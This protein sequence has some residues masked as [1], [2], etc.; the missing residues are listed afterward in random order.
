MIYRCSPTVP[1]VAAAVAA[2]LL[3]GADPVRA[4]IYTI[5]DA[6]AGSVYDGLLDGFPFPPPG[7]AP[8]G[9][10][11]QTT[12]TLAVALLTGVTEERGVVELPLAELVGIAAGDVV[13]ATLTLNIDDVIGTFG[14][15]TTFDGTAAESLFLWSYAGNGT[16]DL[17]DFENIAGP[18]L[19][20]IDTTSHGSITDA[21][22][23]VSGPLAF[24]VDVTS[25][26]VTGLAAADEFLGIL[27]ATTDSGSAT[28]LDNLG[29]GGA[30]PAGVSGS[31]LPFLTVVT[32]SD[33]PPVYEKG[34]LKCQKQVAK[35]STRLESSI[36][37]ALAKCMDSVL[38]ATSKGG[39]ATKAR[40]ICDSAL[41]GTEA[42]STVGKALAKH[43]TLVGK[44]C[45]TVEPSAIGA[46]CA[47]GSPALEVVIECL[48]D[49]ELER[50]QSALRDSY[51]SACALLDAVGFGTE[52]A[53][54]CDAD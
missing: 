41:D 31:F 28:S 4:D 6:S 26:V 47:G 24:D 2:L 46:P 35:A 53:V 34:E 32:V 30:G 45:A 17:A 39:D 14:P 7:F 37:N 27:I 16:I 22:L 43:A 5:D 25:A 10:A 44:A 54:I 40:D 1:L 52:Y 33:D 49:G 48:A 11:D 3:A 9:A 51:A 13:S 36:R 38:L 12:G 21:T 23:A 15:G 50:A 8:D 18:P 29:S 20:S 19:G 42:K